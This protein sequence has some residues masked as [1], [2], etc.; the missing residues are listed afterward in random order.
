MRGDYVPI[1]ID[2]LMALSS[3]AWMVSI[4][5]VKSQWQFIL[6]NRFITGVSLFMIPLVLM[7]LTLIVIPKKNEDILQGCSSYDLVDSSFLPVYLGYFFVALS[8]PDEITLV[9]LMVLLF[10]FILKTKAQFF[11][12][13]L[14]LFGYHFYNVTTH[15]GS[16]IFLIRKGRIAR[17]EQDIVNAK[18]FRINDSTYL[19]R[20]KR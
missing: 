1:L 10:I 8:I 13:T 5:G 3:I 14:L 16:K 4:Y 2:S 18:L 9:F 11:N 6:D 12:P 20:G 19:E 7:L 17:R 15:A